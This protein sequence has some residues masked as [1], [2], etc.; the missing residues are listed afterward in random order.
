MNRRRPFNRTPDYTG[1]H[2]SSL[3]KKE[4]MNLAYYLYQITDG[5]H[6]EQKGTF[7]KIMG[8]TFFSVLPPVDDERTIGFAC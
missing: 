2:L 8:Y 5:M 1:E 3:E 7:A 6:N 4:L